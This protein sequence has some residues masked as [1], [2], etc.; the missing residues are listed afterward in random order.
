MRVIFAGLLLACFSFGQLK[1]VHYDPTAPAF[2]VWTSCT[3]AL[4]AG[5]WVNTCTNGVMGSTSQAAA[6]AFTQAINVMPIPANGYIHAIT[7]KPSTAC[8]GITSVTLIGIGVTGAATYY[9]TGL[10][11]DLKAAVSVTNLFN[12]ILTGTGSN[13]T[14]ATI[15]TATVSGTAQNVS[16]ITNGCAFT[17]G[18]LWSQRT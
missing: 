6:G 18:A 16:G 3:V 15:L 1:V 11:Y 5:S 8:V 9:A 13:T 2:P 17:I 7:V 4:T 12:P 14:A 10:A